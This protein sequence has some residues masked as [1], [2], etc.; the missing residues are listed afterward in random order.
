MKMNTRASKLLSAILALA[1]FLTG[2]PQIAMAEVPEDSEAWAQEYSHHYDRNGRLMSTPG[3]DLS[4]VYVAYAK[5]GEQGKT[6]GMPSIAKQNLESEPTTESPAIVQGAAMPFERRVNTSS[7]IRFDRISDEPVCAPYSYF[8]YEL[9]EEANVSGTGTHTKITGF[10]GTYV[11]LRLDVS[12]LVESLPTPEE[13]K[14]NYLHVKQK[15]NAAL[16][17][18]YGYEK[19]VKGDA[20]TVERFSYNTQG[21]Q[22]AC[23]CLDDNADALKDTDGEH[24]DKPYV[25]I[26][27]LSSGSLVEGADKGTGAS[28]PN[29][30]LPDFPISLY[31]D[32]T[33]DYDPSI[34]WDEATKSIIN[35]Q[36]GEA[37]Q[38]KQ[39]GDV[40]ITPDEMMMDKFYNEEKAKEAGLKDDDITKYTVKGDDL[41]LEVEVDETNEDASTSEEYWSLRRAMDYQEY[42]EHTIRL[43]CEAPILDGLIL[44]GANR[45]VVLDVNSFDIQIA[46]NTETK[47]AGLTVSGGASLEIMDGSNTTGAEL[48]V[49]NNAN[50]L[51]TGAG[52][53]LTI[54]ETCQME[55]EYDSASKTA[56]A[57]EPTPTPVPAPE[58]LQGSLIIENGGIVENQGVI[59]VEG[60]EGKAQDPVDAQTV[61]RDYKDAKLTIGKDGTLINNGCML[62]NGTLYNLGKIENNG[63]Y[64]DLITSDDPDKG[65]F[66][67]HKGIQFSWKDDITQGNTSGGVLSNG[68]DEN[69]NTNEDAELINNGDIV[70]VPGYFINSAKVENTGVIYVSAVKEVMIPIT[71]TQDA[72][73]VVEERI[74]LGYY[75]SSYIVNQGG[76]QFNNQGTVQTGDF[77]IVSNGRTGDKKADVSPALNQLIFFNF[78]DFSNKGDG[79]VALSRFYNS[80]QV[81]NQ[82]RASFSLGEVATKVVM[83][84]NGTDN[85][86]FTDSSSNRVSEVYNAKKVTEDSGNVWSYDPLKELSVTP[87]NSYVKTGAKADWTIAATPEIAGEN[88]RYL[89]DLMLNNPLQMVDTFAVPAGPDGVK[90][91][92]PAAPAAVTNQTYSFTADG[93]AGKS[94]QAVLH[95]NNG[96]ESEQY[97][98]GIIRPTAMQN[99]VYNGQ[100]QTLVTRG[101]A[102]EGTV[103]YQLDGGAFSDALPTA[104]D[105]G[106]Y[107]VKYRVVKDPIADEPEVLDQGTVLVNINKRPLY[108]A[109]DD[110]ATKKGK[111]LSE[112]TYTAFGLVAGDEAADKLNI[113]LSTDATSTS[114][115]GEYPI[116]LEWDENSACAKNYVYEDAEGDSRITD[117]RYFITNGTLD[118]TPPAVT[119][120]GGGDPV[121]QKPG[122]RSYFGGYRN[123][124]EAITLTAKYLK[125]ETQPDQTTVAEVYYSDKVELD[126]DNYQTDGTKA[127]VSYAAVGTDKMVYYYIVTPT[128][129]VAGSQRIVITKADQDAIGIYDAETNKRGLKLEKD[130]Q[131][132]GGRISNIEPRKAEY[133]RADQENYTRI[134]NEVID[135]APGTYYVRKLGDSRKNPGADT[136][137]VFPEEGNGIPVTF[138]ANAGSFGQDG[139]GHE[140]K[141]KVVPVYFGETVGNGKPDGNVIPNDPTREDGV[142]FEEWLLDGEPFDFEH[143]AITYPIELDADWDVPTYTVTFDSNGGTFE[144]NQRV[145]EGNKAVKP[146]D[147]ERDGYDFGGWM[148][149]ETVYDFNATVTGNLNL[150]AAWNPHT[151][152]VKFDANGGTGE[153]QNESFA[154]NE[155]KALTQN[156]FTKEGNEFG[157]WNTQADGKGV[158]Y[159]DEEKVNRLA[160]EKDAVVTLYAQWKKDLNAEGITVTIAGAD[161]LIYNGKAKKPNVTV[162]DGSTDI[163]KF[164]SFTYTN[165][166]NA[167]KTG[168]ENA[169]TVTVSVKATNAPYYGTRTQKFTIQ[170]DELDNDSYPGEL[171]HYLYTESVSEKIDLSEYLPKDAGATTF[172]VAYDG[173]VEYVTGGAPKIVEEDGKFYLTYGVEAANAPGRNETIYANVTMQNYRG[174]KSETPADESFTIEFVLD[175][176]ALV[177]YEKI[178][179]TEVICQDKAMT[180][181]AKMTLVP[182]FADADAGTSRIKWTSSYPEVATVTQDGKVTALT[183]GRTE[184]T[185][186]TET[187]NK[188]ALCNVTVLEPVSALSVDKKS[189]SMG[190]GEVVHIYASAVPYT[191][192][193]TLL[194]TVNNENARILKVSEDTLSATV[195]ADKAGSVKITAQTMDGSNKKA[196]TSITIGKRVPEFTITAKGNVNALQ[197]GKTLGFKVNWKG[198]KPKNTNLIWVV[199]TAYGDDAS[200]IAKISKNGVL[201]GLS[202]GLVRITATSVANP[203]RSASTEVAVYVPVKKVALNVTTGILSLAE[204]ANKLDLNAL[205]TPGKGGSK[206]TGLTLGTEPVVS[207]EVDPK[208]EDVI[209]VDG[210]G[211]VKIKKGVTTKVKNIPVYATVK[212]FNGYSKK[213]TCK[214]T[215]AD[216][217]V[218]KSLKLSKSS[219]TIGK[220]SVTEISA[221]VN[222]LNADGIRDE[223]GKLRLSWAYGQAGAE[224]GK[225]A[226]A[227]VIE[228]KE[229]GVLKYYIVGE[230]VGNDTL[231]F[232]LDTGNGVQKTATCKVTVKP[233]VKTITFKDADKLETDGLAAGKTFTLKPQFEPDG[234]GTVA[235]TGLIYT[236]SDE[237]IATVSEKGVIKAVAPRKEGQAGEVTITATSIDTKA[238][239]TAP[240]SGSI[241]F[242][243][244]APMSKVVLDKTKL[245]VSTLEKTEIGGRVVESSGYGKVSVALMLPE[246]VTDERIAWTADNDNVV[247]AT[248]DNDQAAT[249]GNFAHAEPQK[250]VTGERQALAV[251][252]KKPGTTKLTG[253]TMDGS[254][255][256]V[257]CTV[258]IRG[259]VTKLWLKEQAA[260]SKGYNKIWWV[261]GPAYGTAIKPGTSLSL[262]VLPEINGVSASNP[263]LKK[264]YNA[265]KKY[266]DTTVSYMSSDPE[267]VT[268]SNTGKITVKNTVKEDDPYVEI[269]VFSSDG[270]YKCTVRVQFNPTL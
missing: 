15:S 43:I 69:Q 35:A 58:L 132:K 88:V 239:G 205:V 60:K 85:L 145:E 92:S 163:T 240:K 259:D 110:Q 160:T 149:G 89:V 136:E 204:G 86:S 102:T 6:L 257:T 263:A 154:F 74:D 171:K 113:R 112:L 195:I 232:T 260:N 117:G 40:V 1:L 210:S 55:V 140:I 71:S 166:V 107:T 236:S 72:P 45:S 137:V 246:N 196:V 22:A 104:T 227:S 49:G 134:V 176:T 115:V 128:D 59:T 231:T 177:L 169:P 116:L 206:A 62:V 186:E 90:K 54:D 222:P 95:V 182:G 33:G 247:L 252:G 25:D 211:R 70:L 12:D 103:Q 253:V 125:D 202:E 4:G 241:T 47:A 270:G 230:A 124:N 242:K 100:A 8:R 131:H 192:D 73:S 170:K 109:A 255:K 97:A 250:T 175:Q 216:A 144:D 190:E 164:C 9:M 219:L 256:K 42:D 23:F 50:M 267:K 218:L 120:A 37:V 17:V 188:V 38:P 199:R 5:K 215:I 99:L 20:V 61:I 14:H 94:A 83:E 34:K 32:Q 30:I 226:I 262:T 123:M 162:M 63:C 126:A 238:D 98:F 264:T 130:Y 198:D 106:L 244:Y 64:N 46:N 265:Y 153:M 201:T 208:Y 129:E 234:E 111:E 16:Q 41:E 165:N 223:N 158:S 173:T 258:T 10:D 39:E 108:L 156:T 66:T 91:Q 75:E 79:K 53:K 157:G 80:N 78:A 181:G 159:Q 68:T 200:K 76:G 197:A 191:A 21:A 31:V 147:P 224:E 96:T 52:S 28:E 29:P 237:K 11:I 203:D 220:G 179:K 184:I 151:Y 93:A 84:K 18:L 233:S 251:H 24:T 168:A 36:T 148:N 243:V 57:E 67:Y 135:L 56:P 228:K 138:H 194:W 174:V 180:V 7:T 266:T 26:I 261:A 178:G 133:R 214:V 213:L 172:D 193:R 183:P 155:T 3:N 225:G 248:I 48:A 65:L 127:G 105:A 268:V 121:A 152:S 119:P 207:Y 143:T 249:D 141:D 185:I 217:N 229:S 254:N 87:A 209:S 122:I 187:G 189:Y 142:A 77:E 235:S 2:L 161:K 44:D 150:K 118:L 139:E 81:Q 269:Y 82:E 19:S 146:N 212:A 245:T 51:I 167:G 114:E 221:L 13:G 27:M 101:S